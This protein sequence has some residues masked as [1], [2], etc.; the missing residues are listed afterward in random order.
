MIGVIP[1]TI[2]IHAIP[3]PGLERLKPPTFETQPLLLELEPLLFQFLLAFDR[4]LLVSRNASPALCFRVD[5]AADQ[6][7]AECRDT[8]QISKI[9]QS[10]FS[11]SSFPFSFSLP[12]L[13]GNV[14]FCK[15]LG[16]KHLSAHC[17]AGIAVAVPKSDRSMFGSV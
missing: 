1:A 14:K 12:Y 2:A 17:E 10:H 15:R 5:S 16:A 11:N 3:V 8:Y 4:L 9:K 13:I 7:K 6:G